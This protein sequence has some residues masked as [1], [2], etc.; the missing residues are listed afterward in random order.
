MGLF[1]LTLAGMFA[2]AALYISYVEHPARLTLDDRALLRQFKPSYKRGY[3]M[4]ASLAVLSG[5]AAILSFARDRHPAWIVGAV[6]I[7][8]NWPYTMFRMLPLNNQLMAVPENAADAH[9]TEMLWRWGRLHAVRTG[10]GL[11][12]TAM[13]LWALWSFR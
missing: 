13:F 7:L 10:L 12:A 2:G 6:L 9:S 5:M 11:G 1:A 3:V 8:A 4:Q